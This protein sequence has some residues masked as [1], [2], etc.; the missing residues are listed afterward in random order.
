MEQLE[1][2]LSE[3]EFQLEN[4]LQ[5]NMVG[6]YL[7][8]SVSYGA[9][10]WENS[11][12]D[13][14]VV[15]KSPLAV[16]TKLNCLTA[17]HNLQPLL[18]AKGIEIS[19]VLEKYCKTFV[20]PTPYEL[21]FSKSVLSAY[22]QDPLSLCADDPKTDTDLAAHFHVLYIQ[23]I[24]VCGN[25]I[26][27]VFAPIPTKYLLNSLF[28]DVK[29]ANKTVLQ[30]FPATIFSLCRVCAFA[31]NGKMLSKHEAVSWAISYFDVS[32]H[33]LLRHALDQYKCGKTCAS[34]E[35]DIQTTLQF[36]DTALAH[37]HV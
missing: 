32:F 10:T 15:V 9:F 8:G 22:L 19:F 27:N 16:K 2:V 14:I 26:K 36:C 24:V 29:L 12:I 6:A 33:A 3:I 35:F 30:D 4:I 25:A 5:D 21:H 18:P 34:E 7:H 28:E 37:I 1:M 17:M 31:K 20:Y 13:M 23:G 11:D